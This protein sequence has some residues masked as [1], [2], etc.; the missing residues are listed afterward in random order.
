MAAKLPGFSNAVGYWGNDPNCRLRADQTAAKV[1]VL[2]QDQLR[3]NGKPAA[4][5][6]P[7]APTTAGVVACTCDKDTSQNSDFK[8]MTCFGMRY[9][10]GFL[11]FGYSTLHFS[12]AEASSFTLTTAALDLRKKPNRIQIS[13]GATSAII[14]TQD[15]A[16]DNP[17]GDDWEVE[18][19][20]YRR[21]SGD[22]FTLEWSIDAGST[23]YTVAL[24]DGPLY[25]FR[26]ALTGIGKPVGTGTL[27]FRVTLT[28]TSAST[29]ESPTFEI[30]RARHVR[31]RDVNSALLSRPD[32]NA[33]KILVL[34]TWDQEFV[35]R[36][37]ARGRTVDHLGDRLMTTP[38][39]FFDTS[40]TRDT[41]AAAVDDREAGA[42]PFFE[43]TTGV[44]ASQRYAIH[45]INLDV[46]IGDIFTHQSFSERRVQDGELYWYV[47]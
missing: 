33:G 16:F 28:R 14:E 40:V 1:R 8:C 9:A 21:T 24:T 4:L 45:A 18:L 20:A 42:H 29:P 2:L 39:D 30:V 23:W 38:L 5:W 13:S 43:Y 41:P 27:R 3:L 11:K 47:F 22:T 6:L 12:S 17:A 7:V 46:T 19:L 15:K 32:Y 34:K 10:P 35:A 37:V 36:E 44:R 25:G 31:S 26:G